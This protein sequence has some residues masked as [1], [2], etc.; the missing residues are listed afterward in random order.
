MNF[1][2]CF[3]PDSFLKERGTI[4]DEYLKGY[5]MQ[6]VAIIVLNFNGK[7]CLPKCLLA[8]SGLLYK[9]TEVVVVDNGSTDDSLE[10]AKRSFPDYTYISK[11]TNTGFAAGMNTGIK[12]ALAKGHDFIWLMNYDAEVQ[13]ESLN[14]LIEACQQD[15]KR[16]LLSPLI[17]DTAQKVWFSGGKINY[18]RMRVEH[19]TSRR[20]PLGSY[21][22]E[23]LTGCALLVK[24]KVFENIGLL[25]ERFFLY[26]EDA[27]FSKRAQK[28]GYSLWVTPE[29]VVVHEEKSTLNTKKL[30]YLVHYGMLFFAIHTPSILRPYLMAYV[31]MRRATNSFK[32]FFR[33]PFS[34]TVHQAYADYFAKFQPTNKLYIHKLPEQ[35]SPEGVTPESLTA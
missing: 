11:S 21:Q 19:E 24:R 18:F 2:R 9:H 16:A 22:T 6:S 33:A 5:C 1:A 27:E 15:Q 34:Q 7:D 35:G 29:A 12:Y 8:L 25:D 10:D 4:N 20:L 3:L 28:R 14:K 23:F 26:Y 13:P 30:Y 31:T 17:L 32:R